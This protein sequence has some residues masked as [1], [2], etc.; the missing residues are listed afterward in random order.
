MILSRISCLIPHYIREPRG[1]GRKRKDEGAGGRGGGREGKDKRKEGGRAIG[2]GGEEEREGGRVG[3]KEGGRTE[4]I[5]EGCREGGI[6]NREHL[7]S[8]GGLLKALVGSGEFWKNSEK[9]RKGRRR[10]GG[11]IS[12]SLAA[13]GP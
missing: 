5:M 10:R 1:E 12:G 2:R 8:S 13:C 9:G 11:P 7:G 4:G 6:R 3:K